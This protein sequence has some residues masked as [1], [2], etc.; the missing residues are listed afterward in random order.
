MELTKKILPMVS[1]E[2]IFSLKNKKN[3]IEKLQLI[4]DKNPK[5]IETYQRAKNILNSPKNIKTIQYRTFIN[6]RRK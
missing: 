3:K 6:Q 4:I 2:G 1:D 5:L